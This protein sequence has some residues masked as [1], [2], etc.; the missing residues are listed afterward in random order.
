MMREPAFFGHL[1]LLT[2]SVDVFIPV[3]SADRHGIKQTGRGRGRKTDEVYYNVY[4]IHV[5]ILSSNYLALVA[6]L[7]GYMGG[8]I[9]PLPLFNVG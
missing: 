5:N 4:F 7:E 3:T 2:N 9:L 6:S 1:V 8:T